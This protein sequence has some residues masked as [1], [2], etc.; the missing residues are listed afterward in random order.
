MFSFKGKNRISVLILALFFF[1][2]G[3]CTQKDLGPTEI[4]WD[5]WGIPH[6]YAE[7][8]T[9]LFY[10]FGWAQMENHGNL[11]L[12][13]YGQARGR[14]A[15]YWGEALLNADRLVH[16]LSI[17]KF[18]QQW[19]ESQRRPFDSYL[20]AFVEGMNAYADAFPDK[21][22]AEAKLV[23][24]VLGTDPLGHALRVIHHTFV[25]GSELSTAQRWSK[26]GSNAWAVAPS[27][28]ASNNALLLVNPHLSWSGFFTWYEAHLVT[29]GL[30]AY[31]VALVGC[32]FLGIA[33]NDYLGW[34]HTNNTYDGADLYELTLTDSGYMFDGEERP[35]QTSETLFKVKQPDGTLRQEL[36]TVRH[37]IHGPVLAV[38]DGKALALRLVGL[39]QPHLFEQYWNMVNATNLS[40]FEKA[41]EPLQQPYFN[42]IYADREGHILYLFNG[43]VP[44]RNKGDWQFWRGIVPGDTSETLWT[45]THV[46]GDLPRVVDPDTGWIQ[47]ANDPP[48]SSTIPKLLDPNDF[49]SYMSPQM[50]PLRPQ[51]SIRMLQEDDL[52]TYEELIAYKHSTR[53]ELA[54]RILDDLISAAK[55]GGN[56]LVQQAVK[57]LEEWDR[58]ADAE[59]RGAILFST[60]YQKLGFNMFKETWDPDRPLE[61]PDGLADP[62]AAVEALDTASK[63]V[64]ALYGALDVPW[65]DVFRL[66]FGDIDLP[67]NGGPGSLGI[68]RVVGYSPDKNNRFRAVGGD[69][70]VAA[71]EFST[72]VRASALLSYGNASQPDSSHRFDQLELFSQK[73][74]R[75]IWKS[76]SEIEAHLE[77]KELI[78]KKIQSP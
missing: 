11:I 64:L 63:E 1:L 61:T 15:E 8:E 68:F 37:S 5:T 52:I 62:G 75:P 25:G 18:A 66:R 6:I 20:E 9:S 59:S 73:T 21:I 3:A 67:G 29:K 78:Q 74:L 14:A 54:D 31:G 57:V 44:K 49:P 4:L 65:G 22:S 7:D 39:D 53:M 56:E 46:Y 28:S 47:N 43:R 34:T 60:W 30:D 36:L 35:F 45:E 19:Y 24:P 50:L 58:S 13:L 71:V 10:A 41:L 42:V 76:R 69:S 17:P 48:W 70:F 51:R 33:F 40:E 32:P 27:R 12:Q 16:T 2:S 72:P 26:M 23:L 77:N 55:E 38:K